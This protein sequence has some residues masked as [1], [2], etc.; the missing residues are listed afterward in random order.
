MLVLRLVLVL[1]IGVE[2][3][4]GEC[5]PDGFWSSDGS[6]I[7]DVTA[8]PSIFSVKQK[9]VDFWLASLYG[10]VM[11]REGGEERSSL[12]VGVRG[13]GHIFLFYL[14]AH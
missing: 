13:G 8:A 9:R 4:G 2:R 11:G 10:T 12:S 3:G 5:S 14:N 6:E 1:G 7:G